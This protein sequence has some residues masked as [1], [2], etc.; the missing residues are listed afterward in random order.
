MELEEYIKKTLLQIVKGVKDA[1]DEAAQYGAVINPRI[2]SSPEKAQIAGKYR[3]VESVDF[4]VGLTI[5]DTDS[6][7]KGI[8]VALGYIKADFGVNGDK[9][10]SAI[11]KIKFS[12]PIAYPVDASD[13]SNFVSKKTDVVYTKNKNRY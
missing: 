10:E 13:A 8:G 6:N 2:I 9:S 5:T 4:E 3:S 11:N 12:V 7:K 1:Q